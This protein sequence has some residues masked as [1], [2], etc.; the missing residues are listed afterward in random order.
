MRT[1]IVGPTQKPLLYLLHTHIINTKQVIEQTSRNLNRHFF[2]VQATFSVPVRKKHPRSPSF[3]VWGQLIERKG[4]GWSYTL[5]LLAI[6]CLVR[7][8]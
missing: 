7:H 2:A 4:I 1:I 3:L 5:M 6:C 8:K